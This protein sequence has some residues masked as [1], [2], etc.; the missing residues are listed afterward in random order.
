MARLAF[1][2]LR[3]VAAVSRFVHRMLYKS[4]FAISMLVCLA[5]NTVY[6]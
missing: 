1:V 4:A 5:W 2:P 3:I 6:A